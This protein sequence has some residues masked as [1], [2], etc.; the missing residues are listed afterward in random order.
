[1]EE[2]AESEPEPDHPEGVGSGSNDQDTSQSQTGA[3]VDIQRSPPGITIRG[4]AEQIRRDAA[5]EPVYDDGGGNGTSIEEQL[6][7]ELVQQ[8]KLAELIESRKRTRMLMEELRIEADLVPKEPVTSTSYSKPTEIRG[9]KIPSMTAK[10]NRQE[11]QSWIN[12]LSM[13]FRGAPHILFD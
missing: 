9:I 6:Q 3:G 5:I 7:N 2:V 11:R 12:S 1:M 4:T 8:Q 13:T 10:F